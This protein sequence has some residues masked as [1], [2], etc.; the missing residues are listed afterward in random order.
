MTQ[1]LAS[2]G[3]D[4]PDASGL[5]ET[6][7]LEVY[8][9]CAQSGSQ[10]PHPREVADRQH[11]RLRAPVCGQEA[12]GYGVCMNLDRPR[13]HR[14]HPPRSRPLHRQG[15]RHRADDGRDLL[16]AGR[17]L[18]RQGRLDAHRRPVQGHARRQW[19]RRRRS[20]AGSGAALTAKLRTGGVG[21]GFIG[22]GASNQGTAEA[23]NLSAILKLPVIFVV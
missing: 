3:A 2:L 10:Q 23:M 14:A 22:D 11:A 7:L 4:A 21:G 20:A 9:P 6:Q 16:Q 5:N 15:R 19:H 17:P 18:S 8:R 1:I 12:V 13:Y